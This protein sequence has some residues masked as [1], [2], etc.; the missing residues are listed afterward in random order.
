MHCDNPFKLRIWLFILHTYTILI[1][2]IIRINYG[3]YGPFS[4]AY[5]LLLAQELMQS[6]TASEV[7]FS[8]AIISRPTVCSERYLDTYLYGIHDIGD[9]V[10]TYQ[11]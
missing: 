6:R 1:Y 3:L 2:Q 10:G 11:D 7:K 9:N 4:L 8:L 5:S